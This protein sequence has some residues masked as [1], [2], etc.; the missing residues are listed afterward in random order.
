ML[1]TASATNI[2]FESPSST[3][4]ETLIRKVKR[5]IMVGRLWYTYP[6][7]GLRAGDFT[8]TLTA[9]SYFIEGGEV[10][11]PIKVNTL[12][13]NDNIANI[14]MGIR[15]MTGDTKPTV[16][17]AA[18]EIV[19]APIGLMVDHVHFDEIAEFMEGTY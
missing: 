2:V 8:S 15:G 4:L 13:I 3:D 19:Y 7:N 14:L 10:K 12:R 1:P 16:L 18:D 5:G 11:A 17:W 9:D 6:I